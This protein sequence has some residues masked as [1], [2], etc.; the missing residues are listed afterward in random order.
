MRRIAKKLYKVT[1]KQCEKIRDRVCS[2]GGYA[3]SE[4]RNL[5]EHMKGVHKMGNEIKCDHS[6]YSS[7]SKGALKM[8]FRRKHEKSS[9]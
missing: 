6:P 9:D 1:L 5:R 7:Y 8:H 4:R 2:E 3:T